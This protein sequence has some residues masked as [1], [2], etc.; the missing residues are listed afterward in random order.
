MATEKGTGN[1]LSEM[2]PLSVRVCVREPL[3]GEEVVRRGSILLGSEMGMGGT[4]CC[5]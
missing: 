2:G 4:L 1:G 3:R 5:D